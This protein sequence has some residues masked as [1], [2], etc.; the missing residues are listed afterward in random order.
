[1]ITLSVDAMGGDEGL[2]V[3][4][5][6]VARFLQNQA[7][8]RLIMVGDSAQIQAALAKEN[9][10]MERVEIVH[11]SEVVGMDESPQHALKNKKIHPCAWRF[12]K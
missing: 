1:M 4:A 3:T 9:V 2:T 11:A 5:P 6:A 10:P 8:V 7:D 12:S